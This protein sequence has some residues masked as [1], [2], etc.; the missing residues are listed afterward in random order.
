MLKYTIVFLFS[1]LLFKQT[2]PQPTVKL[3]LN[4]CEWRFKDC[5][6]III[7]GDIHPIRGMNTIE[8]ES[9]DEVTLYTKSKH[10]VT[11]QKSPKY[12]YFTVLYPNGK[13]ECDEYE[14]DLLVDWFFKVF[15]LP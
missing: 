7:D 14:R 15:I 4:I 8:Y 10:I 13:V 11:I 3:K 12:Y 2:T 9:L 6:N 5:G 1:I